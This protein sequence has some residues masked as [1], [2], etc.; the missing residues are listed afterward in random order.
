[1]G[2]AV[3]P[4]RLLAVI[5]V[6][7]AI[8]AAGMNAE[9]VMALVAE[10]ATALTGATAGVVALTEGDDL[11]YRAVS[12]P[13]TIAIGTR[14]P[15]VTSVPGRC[16][17][18]RA[19]LRIDDATTDDR[20][21]A[22]TR[23]RLGA[24]SLL[25]VPLLYGEAPVGVLEVVSVRVRAFTDEDTETL[26]LLAQQIAIALHRA[27]TYPRP[28]LDNVTDAVTGLGN[29]RAFDERIAAEL[30]RNRRYG[31]SFS[32]ALVD[33]EGVETAIDRLGQAAGD[34]AL[35]EVARILN[36]HT[37]AI[38]AGFRVSADDFAIVMPGTSLE[39]ARIVAERCAA[40]IRD[41]KLCEGSLGSKTGVVE[42]L[43]DETVD[44][45]AGRA[46]QAVR[47]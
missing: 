46:K 5:E 19:P 29:R 10:R 8:A 35:R 41:A 18:E 1:M 24:G 4:E 40:H 9:E 16:V 22:G 13:T 27:Y 21:D 42:A 39:G 47:S 30:T 44:D 17:T 7:N 36:T 25:C 45:L 28:R 32:L 11:V 2:T 23:A 26:R 34:D 38:D 15:R 31:H 33:L 43:A 20:V 12:R 3:R 14:F 6:Q 37:R